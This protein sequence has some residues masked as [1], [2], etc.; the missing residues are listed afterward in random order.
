MK[1]DLLTNYTTFD[2]NYSSIMHYPRSPIGGNLFNFDLVASRRCIGD[3]S[4][5]QAITPTDEQIVQAMYPGTGSVDL[6][7]RAGEAPIQAK[8]FD[9]LLES[10]DLVGVNFE[11]QLKLKNLSDF[12][13]GEKFEVLLQTNDP[14]VKIQNVA[15]PT[16][17]LVN[18]GESVRLSRY[19]TFDGPD[20][21]VSISVTIKNLADGQVA[22]PQSLSVYLSNEFKTPNLSMT[23]VNE[24]D[25][26]FGDLDSITVPVFVKNLSPLYNHQSLSVVL[27]LSNGLT[28]TANLGV[29]AP[30]QSQ[31]L[32]FKLLKS[33]V[34]DRTFAPPGTLD[35]RTVQVR[36]LENNNPFEKSSK[37]DFLIYNQKPALN[38][39]LGHLIEIE[40]NDT[41]GK[42][43]PSG[44][45][46]PVV[47]RNAKIDI[48][49]LFKNISG[50]SLNGR[51]FW[52]RCDLYFSRN[53]G[54]YYEYTPGSSKRE[55][56]NRPLAPNETETQ[57]YSWQLSDYDLSTF[58][59][60]SIVCVPFLYGT[61]D[62][63]GSY[64]DGSFILEKLPRAPEPTPTVQPS[65]S[66]RHIAL[67]SPSPDERPEASPLPSAGIETSGG[68]TEYQYTRTEC[69][70]LVGTGQVCCVGPG[71]LRAICETKCPSSV[72]PTPEPTPTPT[73]PDSGPSTECFSDHFDTRAEC[74][75]WIGANRPNQGWTCEVGAFNRKF[76]C[77]PGATP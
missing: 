46:A 71:N 36:A 25:P 57:N 4:V 15:V 6:I 21:S 35:F 73:A 72:E 33:E 38:K 43:W 17:F 19:L 63:I 55:F 40:I 47:S 34:F 45:S 10:M 22:G 29:L 1:F 27:K 16:G 18:P 5:Q 74:L 75:D 59:L 62:H 65:P 61:V 9:F 23:L 2:Y 20:R 58:D 69:A 54:P 66:P 48:M 37:L 8:K 28:R 77:P 49:A 56:L 7:P 53:D 24:G 64:A 31:T 42:R 39:F 51:M 52:E 26:Y 3:V 76:A 41:T 14:G 12:A 11:L 67:P 32:N 60:G 30:G 70:E 50:N 44:A 68:C 13:W